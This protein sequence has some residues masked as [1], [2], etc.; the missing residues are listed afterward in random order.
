MKEEMTIQDVTGSLNALG[1]SQSSGSISV[2]THT[3]TPFTGIP[4]RISLRGGNETRLYLIRYIYTPAVVCHSLLHADPS[5]SLPD[6]KRCVSFGG[7][8]RGDVGTWRGFIC[9]LKAIS[10]CQSRGS[11]AVMVR[12]YLTVI[13]IICIRIFNAFL[14]MGNKDGCGCFDSFG[15]SFPGLVGHAAIWLVQT[16]QRC[17]HFQLWR[18]T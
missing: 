3:H 14:R 5:G 1:C 17:F 8:N 15:F 2:V 18:D 10:T 6:G 13:A 11:A 9:G 4:F 7:R 12:Y 16:N